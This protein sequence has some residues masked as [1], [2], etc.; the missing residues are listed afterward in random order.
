MDVVGI[1]AAGIAGDVAVVADVVAVD[2]VAV[3]M[4]GRFAGIAD[5]AAANTHDALSSVATEM[6]AAGE[7]GT[8]GNFV[9]SLAVSL[10]RTFAEG[11]PV[12]AGILEVDILVVGILDGWQAVAVEVTRVALA[13]FVA[14][15]VPEAL[16]PQSLWQTWQTRL[17]LPV[18]VLTTGM[19]M[20]G[21]GKTQTVKFLTEVLGVKHSQIADLHT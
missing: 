6:H 10:M 9:A 1:A 18:S 7:K 21:A 20:I 17:R 11:I 16:G 14:L 3:D 19:I 15:L 5:S 2:V 12:A 8:D 13:V 4:G